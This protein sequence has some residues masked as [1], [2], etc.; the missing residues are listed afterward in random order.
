MP[1]DPGCLCRLLARGADSVLCSS[2][3]PWDWRQLVTSARNEGVQPLLCAVLESGGWLEAL[4]DALRRQLT[5][6][7][8]TTGAANWVSFEQLPEILSAIREAQPAADDRPTAVVVKGAVLAAALYPSFKLRPMVD[9]DLLVRRSRLEAV[10]EALKSLGYREEAPEMA[11]GLRTIVRH[12]LSLRGGPL[13]K[14]VL[15]LHW[16]LI[17]GDADRRSPRLEW[18]WETEPLTPTEEFAREVAAFGGSHARLPLSFPQLTPTAHLPYLA[19]HLVLQHGSAEAPLLWFYDIHLLIERCG[20]R[21]DWEEIVRRAREFRWLAAVRAAVEG[22]RA[23]FDTELPEGVITELDAAR[24]PSSSWLIQSL[25]EPQTPATRFWTQ[26]RCL[27][28]TARLR[29]TWKT[30]RP[31]WGLRSMALPATPPV[32]VASRVSPPLGGDE[33]PPGRVDTRQDTEEA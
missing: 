24:E 1:P 23:R 30:V 5:R 16:N 32:V 25:A 21:L 22:T 18:F 26:L 17:G 19:A 6:S 7:R 20:P 9:I 29:F 4:P 14:V 8:F 12:G 33:P 10:L 28:W 13:A 27:G 11:R 31:R 2:L 3:S 15:D